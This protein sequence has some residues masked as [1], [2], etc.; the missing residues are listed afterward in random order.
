MILGMSTATFTLV[1]V[2][3]SLIGIVS[4]FIVLFGLLK[5]NRSDAWTAL[6]LVTT[7]LTSV[8]GLL[9]PAPRILPSQ[10]VGVISLIALAVA[11]F[12]LYRSHLAGAWRWLYVTCA[13][14]ALYLNV[15]VG[16]VQSF[17]KVAFLQPLA[18]TQSEAP[19]L[20]AQLVVMGLFVLLGVL[21]VK[22]FHPEMAT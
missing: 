21:A 12:A 13:V 3:I 4:G 5:A 7:V 2:V 8:T 10:I 20:V 16:V 11:I 9:F 18:P 19:F 15:F 17:Q 1:H 22:R 14:F 6:F